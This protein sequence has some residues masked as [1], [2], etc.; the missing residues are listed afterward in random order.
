MRRGGTR[1]GERGKEC[2]GTYKAP[3]I[4]DTPVQLSPMKPDS[5]SHGNEPPSTPAAM[6]AAGIPPCPPHSA[7][8][9]V[10]CGNPSHDLF[11]PQVRTPSDG[12]CDLMQEGGIDPHSLSSGV[13]EVLK[14]LC[15]NQCA[16]PQFGDEVPESPSCTPKDKHTHPFKAPDVKDERAQARDEEASV[17]GINASTVRSPERVTLPVFVQKSS[18]RGLGGVT[19]QLF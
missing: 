14:R 7:A 11:R 13:R 8:D 4:R 18:S 10:G 1:R 12:L 6:I 3:V 15:K 9:F 2:I 17:G 19:K 5:Q 16:S